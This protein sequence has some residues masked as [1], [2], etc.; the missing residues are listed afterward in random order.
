MKFSG[1]VT[2]LQRDI[3][4]ADFPVSEAVITKKRVAIDWD[5]HGEL[6]HAVLYSTDGGIIYTGNYGTPIPKKNW[7]MTATKYDAADGSVLLLCKWV[8]EDD[9][10][11]NSGASFFELDSVNEP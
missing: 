6:F 4:D 10:F 3:D 5:E 1:V 8:Q 11:P 2:E 9:E 7:F